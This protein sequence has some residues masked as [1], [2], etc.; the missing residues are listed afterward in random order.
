MSIYTESI[1]DKIDSQICPPLFPTPNSQKV[2]QEIL[3]YINDEGYFEGNI[4]TIAL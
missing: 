2:A 4:E 3:F 1:Y